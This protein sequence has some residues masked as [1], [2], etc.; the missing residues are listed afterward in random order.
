MLIFKQIIT[1]KV[2]KLLINIKIIK[3]LY[4]IKAILID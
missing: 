1:A 4:I 2:T 3:S